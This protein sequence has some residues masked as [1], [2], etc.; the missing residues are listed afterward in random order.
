M[1]RPVSAARTRGQHPLGAAF[2]GYRATHRFLL[3]GVAPPFHAEDDTEI[4]GIGAH[5]GDL[6]RFV[7][8]AGSVQ[9]RSDH[10]IDGATIAAPRQ[11]KS[12]LIHYFSITQLKCSVSNQHATTKRKRPLARPLCNRRDA[13]RLG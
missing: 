7:H 11:R 8:R 1:M 10:M 3:H 2:I 4:A 12:E 13:G 6:A 5:A 9:L